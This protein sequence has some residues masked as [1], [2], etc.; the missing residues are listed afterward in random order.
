MTKPKEC[1]GNCGTS[2]TLGKS[3][4][5]SVQVCDNPNTRHWKHT[6][7]PGD[8]CLSWS[9]KPWEAIIRRAGK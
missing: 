8:T 7:M 9:P 5:H 4:P 2:W 6:R 1:C 3:R